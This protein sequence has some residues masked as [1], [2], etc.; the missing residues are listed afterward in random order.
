MTT[1][2]TQTPD[3]GWM[4]DRSRGSSMGRAESHL[5]N[6][7][8]AEKS[9]YLSRVK[10]DCRGYDSGG[11]YWGL[12]RPLYCAYSEDYSYIRYVR[13]SSREEAAAKLGLTNRELKKPLNKELNHG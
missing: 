8:I 5:E 13:A 6:E 1:D 3:T 10:I 7:Q 12:G 11:C 9:I 4:G 2:P